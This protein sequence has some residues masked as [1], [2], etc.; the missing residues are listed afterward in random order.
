[1]SGGDLRANTR[2][3]VEDFIDRVEAIIPLK[4][5]SRGCLARE[6]VVE[7]IERP[8][9]HRMGMSVG[10]KWAFEKALANGHAARQVDLLHQALGQGIKKCPRIEAVIAGIQVEVL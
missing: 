7:K 10:E 3:V 9:G 8:I 1:M 5:D 4:H 6:N 2:N